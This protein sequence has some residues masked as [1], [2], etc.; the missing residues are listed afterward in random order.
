MDRTFFLAFIAIFVALDIIG[1]LPLYIGMTREMDRPERNRVVNQSMLIALGVAVVFIFLGEAIFR[2]LGI[3]LFDF[4]I[5]GG[6]VLLLISLTDLVGNPEFAN[7]ASGHSGIVPLAV[8]LITGP[9]VLTTV[10]LQAGTAGYLITLTALVLNYIFAWGLLRKSET[11]TRVIGRDGTV[12]V[13]KLAALLL[14]AIAIAM[15]RS[16]VFEAIKFFK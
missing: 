4:K 5:A 13:S 1:T 11:I 9:G 8:P 2:Y 16:G 6:I 3:E 10:I 12:V 15:V 14:A 7:R